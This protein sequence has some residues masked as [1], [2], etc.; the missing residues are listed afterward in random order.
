MTQSELVKEVESLRRQLHIKDTKL[1]KTQLE[2]QK[3]MRENQ[4]LGLKMQF[5]VKNNQLLLK[6]LNRMRQNYF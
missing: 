2:S 5:E 1:K 6:N 4:S 3:I